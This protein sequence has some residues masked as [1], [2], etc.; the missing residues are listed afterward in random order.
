LEKRKEVRSM[1]SFPLKRFMTLLICLV[2]VFGCGCAIVPQREFKAYSNAFTEAKG[3]TEKL[4]L[5]YDEAKRVE[6]EARSKPANI[7]LIHPYPSNVTLSVGSNTPALA[8]PVASRREA[9][10]LVSGFNAVLLSLAEG[11]KLEEVRSVTDSFLENLTGVAM[12]FNDQFSIPYVGQI[13]ALISTVITKLQEAENRYQFAVALKE[14]EPIIQGIL[15][16]FS[17]DAE[18]IYLIRARQADRQW[19]EAQDRVATLVRQMKDVAKEHAAPEGNYGKKLAAVEKDVRSLLDRVGLKE[20]KETLPTT[21]QS[22]FNEL[23][24][25]QLDQTLL[26]AKSEAERYEIVIKQQ[27]AFH[28]LIVS[29]GDLLEK[30]RSSLKAVRLALD[31]PPDIRQQSKEL[32]SFAFRVKRD[33]EA[34]D[35]ARRGSTAK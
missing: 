24:L 22:V 8:D 15:F 5:E 20:N 3:V 34:F 14:S 11:K 1:K 4:L 12:L 21:G 30:T 26:Q 2:V 25:S 18:D 29:Y 32:L 17:K 10:E 27:V 23:T 31:A 9:L 7:D 6:A 13:G 33:W 16:L 28:K 19:S 35:A